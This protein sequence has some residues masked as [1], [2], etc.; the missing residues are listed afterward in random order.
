MGEERE[1]TGRKGVAHLDVEGGARNGER[2]VRDAPWN[3]H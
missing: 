3:G 1:N 2:D